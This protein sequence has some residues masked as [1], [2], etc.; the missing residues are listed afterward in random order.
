LVHKSRGPFLEN[1]ENLAP[2]SFE[3]KNL[4]LKQRSYKIFRPSILDVVSTRTNLAKIRLSLCL[5]GAV[6][7]T[8]IVVKCTAALLFPTKYYLSIRRLSR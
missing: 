5:M 1:P 3:Q 7:F 4:N 6:K 8:C 2:E